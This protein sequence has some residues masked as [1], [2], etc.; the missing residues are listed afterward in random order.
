MAMIKDSQIFGRTLLEIYSQ[1]TWYY[2]TQ[3]G[4]VIHCPGSVILLGKAGKEEA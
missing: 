2:I 4:S 3:W 1:I